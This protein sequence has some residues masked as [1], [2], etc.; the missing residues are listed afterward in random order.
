MP[1]NY[2]GTSAG[3]L[4]TTKETENWFFQTGLEYV[5]TKYRV[6]SL[7]S[8]A[9]SHGFY[10]TYS[11]LMLTINTITIPFYFN[12]Y[13]NKQNVYLGV[14]PNLDFMTFNKYE[15]NLT[16]YGANG[17][18]LP[19]KVDGTGEL[20]KWFNIGGAFKVGYFL[21]IKKQQ[22]IIEAKYKYGLFNLISSNYQGGSIVHNYFTLNI[23]YVIKPKERE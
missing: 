8:T 3:F 23:G 11:N 7:N 21:K 13:L 20:T 14:G 16:S 5:N 12:L 17:T 10:G 1:S 18:S 2:F 6:N 9:T 22:F 15:G 4:T 19:V